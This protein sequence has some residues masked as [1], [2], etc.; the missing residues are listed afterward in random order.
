MAAP[1]KE[2]SEKYLNYVTLNQRAKTSKTDKN[3]KSAQLAKDAYLE[4]FNRR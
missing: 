3:I 4:A 2:L 1:Y